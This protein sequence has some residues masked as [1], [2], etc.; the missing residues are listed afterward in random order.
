MSSSFFAAWR[1]EVAS[2]GGQVARAAGRAAEVG[3]G[4]HGR[5]V[6][7]VMAADAG[8]EVGDSVEEGV[9]KFVLEK[10]VFP[11]DLTYS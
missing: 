7:Q 11:N 8:A 1:G 4:D 2:E 10:S 9:W 6:A 5:Q 3:T